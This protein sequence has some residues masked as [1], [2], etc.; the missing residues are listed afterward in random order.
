VL[1]DSSIFSWI[2]PG[3]APFHFTRKR[4]FI[5]RAGVPRKSCPDERLFIIPSGGARGTEY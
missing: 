3:L 4:G 5:V 2:F 1:E